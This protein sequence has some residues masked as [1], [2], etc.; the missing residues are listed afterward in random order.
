MHKRSVISGIIALLFVALLPGCTKNAGSDSNS[1]NGVNEERDAAFVREEDNK[2]LFVVSGWYISCSVDDGYIVFI[3]ELP[4]GQGAILTA[5]VDVNISTYDIRNM[6]SFQTTT[7]DDIVAKVNAPEITRGVDYSDKHLLAY[8]DGDDRYHI[9]K[10]Y[11]EVE[12]LKNGQEYMHYGTNSNTQDELEPFWTSLSIGVGVSG[13]VESGKMVTPSLTEDEILNMTDE[14]LVYYANLQ[15]NGQLQDTSC[16]AYEAEGIRFEEGE[17]NNGFTVSPSDADVDE[18]LE[19]AVQKYV[20]EKKLYKER[21]L[22]CIGDY[23]IRE[24]NGIRFRRYFILGNNL[25]MDPQLYDGSLYVDEWFL[26]ESGV[27][28]H[29]RPLS[30]TDPIRTIAGA[31]KPFD[32]Y[33]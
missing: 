32:M 9:I 24:N 16:I 3:P 15:Y 2:D 26:S 29:I 18:A 17:E 13:S 6:K 14:E 33:E 25:D 12:V 8:S 7:L 21:E 5:D 28:D 31:D 10:S 4:E 30:I 11:N 23:L 22:T 19:N 1:K 20:S 27:I